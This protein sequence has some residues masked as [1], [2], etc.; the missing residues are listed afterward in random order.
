MTE[1]WGG[2]ITEGWDGRSS[3]WLNNYGVKHIC[4]R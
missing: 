1:G 2:D 3:R 4:L